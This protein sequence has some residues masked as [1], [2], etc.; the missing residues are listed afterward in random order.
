MNA[1]IKN[2]SFIS[3]SAI[4]AVWPE[5]GTSGIFFIFSLIKNYFFAF[6]IKLIWLGVGLLNRTGAENR[7]RLLTW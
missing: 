4:S 3:L 7:N 6:F 5:L 1:K 2:V